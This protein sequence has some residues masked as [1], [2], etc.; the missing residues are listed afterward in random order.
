MFKKILAASVL[1]GLAMASPV[2]AQPVPA[3]PASMNA[4]ELQL[5]ENG[6]LAAPTGPLFAALKQLYPREYGTLLDEMGAL[7]LARL[8]D[9]AKLRAIGPDAMAKVFQ[10][11]TPDVINA[12]PLMLAKINQGQLDLIRALKAG[13]P[14]ECA[15]FVM[16]GFD[17]QT[18][19]PPTLHAKAVGVSVATLEAAKAGRELPRDPSRGSLN[20]QARRAWLAKMKEV[21]PSARIGQIIMDDAAQQSATAEEKCQVGEAIYTAIEKLPPEQAANIGA[22]MLAQSLARD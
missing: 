6:L 4:K 21:A 9:P 7:T 14:R 17:A 15:Q 8:G 20:E 1:S 5:F 19:L 13:H 11:K 16:T 10:R 2:Q 12:P 18:V 3:A 22:F